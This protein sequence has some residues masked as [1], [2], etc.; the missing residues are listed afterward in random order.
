MHVM[1]NVKYIY[2]C[3]WLRIVY[4]SM[5]NMINIISMQVS[6]GYKK[7]TTARRLTCLGLTIDTSVTWRHHITELTS[8]LNKAC[9]AIRL[10][11]PFMSIAVQE[12]FLSTTIQ[13]IKYPTSPITIYAQYLYLLPKIRT[14]LYLTRRYIKLIQ[15]KLL[16]CTYL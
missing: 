6:F 4:L 7:I 1:E 9:Y 5:A 16:T 14:N 12:S 11:K 10:I 2:I 3:G 15:S 13:G 8:R